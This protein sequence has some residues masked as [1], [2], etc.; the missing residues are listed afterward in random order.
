MLMSI[1]K[2][3]MATT[4]TIEFNSFDELSS[5][6]T[7]HDIKMYSC[8][9]FSN[10]R[11]NLDNFQFAEMIALD[12]DNYP[13][14]PQISLARAKELFAS[15]KCLIATTKSH[16]REKENGSGKKMPKADRFRV[17]LFLDRAITNAAD[18]TATWLKLAEMFPGCDKACKDA[19][20]R[21][22]PSIEVRFSNEVGKLVPVVGAPQQKDEEKQELAPDERGELSRKTKDFL[23]NG[24]PEGTWNA[25]L[26]L[27]ARDYLEQG[28]SKEEFI[29][30]GNK[31]NEPLDEKDLI[32]VE[33][34]FSKPAKY[35]ARKRRPAVETWT[36]MWIEKN[37]VE[38]HYKDL[39]LT[40]NGT[41]KPADVIRSRMVLDAKFYA[42]TN[43]I[44]N[45][46]NGTMMPR[47]TFPTDQLEHALNCWLDEEKSRV[48]EDY[49]VLLTYDPNVKSNGLA[50]WLEGITGKVD[51]L[52]LA[53]M[54]HFMWQI[55]RKLFDLQVEWHMMP[56]LIGET[57]GGKSRSVYK[58]LDPI[59][60]LLFEPKTLAVVEDTRDA[61]IFGRFY[62]V[63]FD[64]MSRAS[65]VDVEALK[66]LITSP[67]VSYRRLG[68]N[69]QCVD[70]N[71]S[72]FIGASNRELQDL[73]NDPTSA[74]RYW[75]INT[76]PKGK[77]NWDLLGSV[78]Y[79][80]LWK[81]I[82]ENSESPIMPVLDEVLNTQH[83][84]MR[85][86]SLVEQWLESDI[87]YG[88]DVNTWW[89]ASYAHKAFLEWCAR[90]NINNYCVTTTTFGRQLKQLGVERRRT[91]VGNEYRA[92]VK[93]EGLKLVK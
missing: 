50:D 27:A 11:A 55:K 28:Y 26:Y 64:E 67:R 51:R 93:L 43:P 22:F 36:H 18:Y 61:A 81:S 35:G 78:D 79:V 75:Q 76:L 1:L 53:V 57:G 34:A 33:S 73:I 48:I 29:E 90:Q 19:S 39:S 89:P 30:V 52:D 40:Y 86:K 44:K 45:E 16:Q 58:L 46:K 83:R 88:P 91:T 80:K 7:N 5:I 85:A 87:S 92:T 66:N 9:V 10:Q 77:A 37:K 32:T 70:P 38:F 59:E 56:V 21:M 62:A 23:K 69:F 8:S 2:N 65:K 54:S 63:Y 24:A 72:T 31:V 71:V 4:E 20:R 42:E 82:D 14:E 12:Y 3:D 13:N 68:T 41:N 84:E 47:P 6:V 25:R 15:Y 49:Q 74:R 60:E 17:I